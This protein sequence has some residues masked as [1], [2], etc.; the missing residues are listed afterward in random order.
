MTCGV[1]RGIPAAIGLRRFP[2]L[3]ENG[4]NLCRDN[5]PP[6]IEIGGRH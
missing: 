4:N 3:P 2:D 6:G 1:N 5:N